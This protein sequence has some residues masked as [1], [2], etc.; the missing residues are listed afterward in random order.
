[1]YHVSIELILN[2]FVT[3]LSSYNPIYMTL[4]S[5]VFRQIKSPKKVPVCTLFDS[6]NQFQFS[7]NCLRDYVTAMT[8]PLSKTSGIWWYSNIQT[9]WQSRTLHGHF[10]LGRLQV[11]HWPTIGQREMDPGLWLAEDK[12]WMAAIP[13]A[14]TLTHWGFKANSCCFLVPVFKRFLWRKC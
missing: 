7:P 11:Q 6:F 1:M 8:S 10:G 5:Y 14:F 9:F 4:Q 2:N 12:P 13:P 3:Q